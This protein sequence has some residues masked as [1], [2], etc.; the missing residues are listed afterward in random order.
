MAKRQRPPLS[1][2]RSVSAEVQIS[3][4]R[5]LIIEYS[6][7]FYVSCVPGEWLL[8]AGKC[9]SRALSA[10]FVLWWVSGMSKYQVE[11]LEV[12]DKH[13][14][15]WALTKFDYSKGLKAL[16]SAGLVKVDRRPGQPSLV[17]IFV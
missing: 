9:G 12:R 4:A 5:Q 14:E 6:G 17:T 1:Y 10:G 15:K 2:A 3:A 7:G 11:K 13:R 8:A 16:E